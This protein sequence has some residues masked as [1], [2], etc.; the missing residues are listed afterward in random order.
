ML[1]LIIYQKKFVNGNAV[2]SRD[3]LLAYDGDVLA[4]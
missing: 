1:N 3:W 4:H 2:D